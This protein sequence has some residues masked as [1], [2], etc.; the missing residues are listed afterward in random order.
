MT[1]SQVWGCGL[2][3]NNAFLQME[4]LLAQKSDRMMH[5]DLPFCWVKWAG[6]HMCVAFRFCS[7]NGATSGATPSAKVRST[8][9]DN[10]FN[11]FLVQHPAT[12]Q[13]T[14]RLKIGNLNPAVRIWTSWQYQFICNMFHIH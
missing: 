4:L 5:I 12:L 11:T 1:A 8:T 7:K 3:G 14:A 2:G 9:T 13:C 10:F 6:P